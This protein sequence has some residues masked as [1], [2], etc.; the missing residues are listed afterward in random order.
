MIVAI[1]IGIIKYRLYEK[2]YDVVGYYHI[3]NII[4]VVSIKNCSGLYVH[5]T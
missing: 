4:S 3:I 2:S 1:I 5:C